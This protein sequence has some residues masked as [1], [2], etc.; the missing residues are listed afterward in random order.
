MS[1]PSTP[2][3]PTG[4]VQDELLVLGPAG[5]CRCP[6]RALTS[7]CAQVVLEGWFRCTYTNVFGVCWVSPWGETSLVLSSSAQL[8]L[9]DA[10]G[11]T[12]PFS[13]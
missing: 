12:G 5:S 1:C 11:G 9:G 6:H 2:W 13:G 3:P 7:C 4:A 8:V 10:A